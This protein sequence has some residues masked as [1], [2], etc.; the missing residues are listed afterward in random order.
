MG[1][2]YPFEGTSAQTNNDQDKDSGSPL[3]ARQV[4]QTLSALRPSGAGRR[5]H[6]S[7]QGWMKASP[8]PLWNEPTPLPSPQTSSRNDPRVAQQSG[9]FLAA[10]SEHMGRD[11]S[12][13]PSPK[14][15]SKPPSRSAQP[16]CLG[17]W[18]LQC[19]QLPSSNEILGPLVSSS[20]ERPAKIP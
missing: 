17:C 15:G 8:F 14:P 7:L 16:R 12:Q 20:T 19:P 18:C 2:I 3:G 1:E 9:L 10:C 4:L 5:P 11:C 6:P 13:D